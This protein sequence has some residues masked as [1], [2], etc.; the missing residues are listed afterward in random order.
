MEFEVV[1]ELVVVPIS[2]SQ[3]Q[4]TLTRLIASVKMT[5]ADDVGEVMAASPVLG[6]DSRVS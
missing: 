1:V 5:I 3:S 4:P 6:P 2:A